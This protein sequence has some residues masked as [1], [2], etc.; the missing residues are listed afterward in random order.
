MRF[1]CTCPDSYTG[2]RC[3]KLVHPR[4][5]KGLATNGAKISSGMYKVY[6]SQ[7]KSFQVYCDFD[8][9][10]GNVWTLMQS[11]SFGNNSKFRKKT[12]DVDYPVN[13]DDG[14]IHWSAYRLS[15]SRMLSIA[16]VST[17]L[18]ATCNFPDE[19]LVYTDYARANLQGH[20]LFRTW[21]GKCKTYELVNIRGIECR[22]CTVC[23]RQK[24]DRMW[25]I[26]SYGIASKPCEFDGKIGAVTNEQNFGRY[27]FANPAFR[28]TS[29]SDS[30]TQHWIGSTLSN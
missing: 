25:H 4:S 2:Q 5:C 23:T 1:N 7:N 16:D 14:A 9:E 29:N 26:C 30:T 22:D 13:Q 21:T 19:G 8:S 18:R 10:V 28:C 20:N 12:F 11:F 3:E 15:L 6:D 27:N 17:H 24:Q